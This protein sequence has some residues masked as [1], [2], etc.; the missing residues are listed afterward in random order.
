MEGEPTP[1]GRTRPSARG[2][3]TAPGLPLLNPLRILNPTDRA[4]YWTI[5]AIYALAEFRLYVLVRLVV[6][7][8]TPLTAPLTADS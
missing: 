7:Y 5:Y 1:P 4:T 6:G 8:A 2:V 3:W